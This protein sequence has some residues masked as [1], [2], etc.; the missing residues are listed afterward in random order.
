[1]E[2]P[3]PYDPTKEY[4]VGDRV[5]HPVPASLGTYPEPWLFVCIKHHTPNSGNT[6]NGFYSPW[7]GEY[8][9]DE[10]WYGDG[11]HREY[12]T[13]FLGEYWE[14]I[15]PEWDGSKTYFSGAIVQY[16]G[17]IYEATWRYNQ[18]WVP[19][20][21]TYG[22]PSGQMT[23][24]G[25]REERTPTLLPPSQDID[26]DS[27]R[28]WTIASQPQFTS[29]PFV[30][31]PY[32]F[33]RHDNNEKTMKVGINPYSYFQNR[34]QN[35]FYLGG[36]RNG[37][38][39][40][41]TNVYG[42]SLEVYLNYEAFNF[43]DPDPYLGLLNTPGGD[44]SA[45]KCGFAFQTPYIG[46]IMHSA[47]ISS[48]NTDAY[49]PDIRYTEPAAGGGGSASPDYDEGP[50]RVGTPESPSLPSWMGNARVYA[51]HD[52]P[53]YH[54][55]SIEVK[56]LVLSTRSW[57]VRYIPPPPLVPG[58]PPDPGYYFRRGNQRR[59]IKSST[60]QFVI[61]SHTFGYH[62]TDSR[63]YDPELFT[64]VGRFTLTGGL[65]SS[66]SLLVNC[67]YKVIE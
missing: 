67:V 16:K 13:V 31:C 20:G 5:T 51:C 54:K 11:Y 48:F 63:E 60:N 28:T 44:T 33:E 58:E 23:E 46:R 27:V 22:N 66:Q 24:G 2:K 43:P 50:P 17:R 55:R 42:A 45:T 18:K 37:M 12:H 6:P 35:G 41:G 14:P 25:Q 38:N 19:D 36:W 4:F 53:L 15:P 7:P 8:G 26:E 59:N 9:W 64:E 3:K 40:Y 10:R 57:W 65:D 49:P 52:H 34:S 39:N 62:I 61:G 29:A 56:A 21:T 30:F 1:M 47:R 32:N